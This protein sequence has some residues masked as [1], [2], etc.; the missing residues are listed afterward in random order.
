MT[1]VTTCRHINMDTVNSFS[2]DPTELSPSLLSCL[3]CSQVR[4]GPLKLEAAMFVDSLLEESIPVNPGT[5]LGEL[6]TS[7]WCQQHPWHGLTRQTTP[8]GFETIKSQSRPV[9][10]IF[11]IRRTADGHVLA[12]PA[13]SRSW[14]EMQIHPDD[15]GI[16]LGTA[17]PTGTIERFG[18][19][20]A[21]LNQGLR[22]GRLDLDVLS[23][24][25]WA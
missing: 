12:F 10:T 6:L 9:G 15:A 25:K 14:T 13:G 21:F 16:M 8:G 2:T 22:T 23:V 3:G 4:C 1:E 18:T 19:V 5:P 7:E 24:L 17:L 20:W 11:V